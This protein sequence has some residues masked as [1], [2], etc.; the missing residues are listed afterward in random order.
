MQLH[1]TRRRIRRAVTTSLCAAGAAFAMMCAHGQ[2]AVA[3]SNLD[4][5]DLQ[6][7]AKQSISAERSD[8]QGPV[9][10]GGVIALSDFH[11][12][13]DLTAG[14]RL[15]F[16][17]G[18]VGG[19]VR[20]PE[21]RTSHVFSSGVGPLAG[22]RLEFTALKLDL[23]G[24]RL[25][26]LSPTSR[27][28]VGTGADGKT[29]FRA[30]A[31]R[32]LE[33]VDLAGDRLTAAGD[34]RTRLVLTGDARSHLLV[35]VH[36]RSVQMR[37]LGFSVSG[38]LDPAR[39][40]LFFPEANDLEIAFS[41]GAQREDGETWNVPGSIVAPNA[42]LRF[43]ASTVTGQ[44]FA[45]SIASI[46]GLPGGQVDR[47][48]PGPGQTGQF[49]PSQLLQAVGNDQFAAVYPP[50]GGMSERGTSAPD[51]GGCRMICTRNTATP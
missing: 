23:L 39:I 17:R 16:D 27:I 8:Y 29:E 9:A 5:T 6:V 13:G 49:A 45:Q 37:H 20:S 14:T 33:V 19:F 35:R 21:V 18:Q 1:G 42:A 25:A 11:V 15:V 22:N 50:A 30:S 46:P 2:A 7:F 10:A 31:R 26:A 4:L 44:V 40:V 24:A 47:L 51:Q 3:A 38:G 28:A 43:A 32:A 36:G 48:P 41:G 34:D 12:D